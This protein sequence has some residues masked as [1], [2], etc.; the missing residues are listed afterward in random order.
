MS[1]DEQT[2]R[3]AAAVDDVYSIWLNGTQLVADETSIATASQPIVTLQPGLTQVL[4]E[5][6]NQSETTHIQQHITATHI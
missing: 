4:M 2:I 1:V 3:I 6:G 5:V